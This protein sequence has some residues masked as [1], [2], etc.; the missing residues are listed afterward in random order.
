MTQ[1]T[2]MDLIK[3]LGQVSA[4]VV[5]PMLGGAVGGI[6]IDKILRTSPIFVFGGFAAG[7]IIAIVGI[8]LYIRTHAPA[9]SVDRPDGDRSADVA[10]DRD[11]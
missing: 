9:K 6:V 7:N 1:L 4:I 11:T 2:S 10:D 5:I 8:L 3:I